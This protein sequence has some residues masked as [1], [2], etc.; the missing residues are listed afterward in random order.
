MSIF[1]LSGE[2]CVT[3]WR[4]AKRTLLVPGLLPFH[5]FWS[6]CQCI[7]SRVEEAL[8]EQIRREKCLQNEPFTQ[9]M[10]HSDQLFGWYWQFVALDQAVCLHS[11]EIESV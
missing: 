2:S 3:A 11:Y 8:R 6:R 5:P 9:R 7:E 10:N 4:S 1:V